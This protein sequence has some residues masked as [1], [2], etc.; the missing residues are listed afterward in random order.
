MKVRQLQLSIERA[1]WSFDCGRPWHSLTLRPLPQEQGSLR[2]AWAGASAILASCL[3]H[4]SCSTLLQIAEAHHPAYH[5]QDHTMDESYTAKM[6]RCHDT[7]QGNPIKL[8]HRNLECAQTTN[9]FH[10]KS[11]GTKKDDNASIEKALASRKQ[12]ARGLLAGLHLT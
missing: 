5:Q 3:P 2:C 12:Q 6:S 7:C 1:P 9:Q 4:L 11:R 10:S 8:S